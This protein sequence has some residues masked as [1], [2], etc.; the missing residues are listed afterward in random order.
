MRT[1]SLLC[2]QLP[3]DYIDNNKRC[4]NQSNHKG[5]EWN[6]IAWRALSQAGKLGFQAII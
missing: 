2:T 3:P 4:R 6:V 5:Q 1:I